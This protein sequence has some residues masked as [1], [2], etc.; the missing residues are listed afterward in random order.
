MG[1]VV[2][3]AIAFAG[4]HFLLSHPLRAPLIRAIGQKGFLGL[5][6]LV[7][8]ATLIWLVLAYRA[9]PAAALL[10][11]VGDALWAIGTILMLLAAILFMIASTGTS[12]IT[13]NR[14]FNAVLRP[15]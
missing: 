6:S 9:A 4:T 10:W 2:A 11:P 14:R 1:N 5:Y 8:L 7:A 13:R 12:A 15:I 3:A